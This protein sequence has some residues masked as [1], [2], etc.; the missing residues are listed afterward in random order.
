MA[1]LQAQGY[2]LP[3]Y[4]DEVVTDDDKAVR[5]LYGKVMGSAVNPVLREGNS[6][7]RAPKAVKQYAQNNPHSMGAWS[8]ESKINVATMASGDFR[9]NETSVTVAEAGTFRIEHVGEDGTVTVLAPTPQP[10]P[11]RSS[12]RRS[13]RTTRWSSFWPSKLRRQRPK[14]CFRRSISRRR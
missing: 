8:A 1:E 13:W 12:M 3:D 2:A 7:R 11:A 10:S 4:P 9:A 5:A 6:D 14:V